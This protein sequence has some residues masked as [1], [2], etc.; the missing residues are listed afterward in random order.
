MAPRCLGLHTAKLCRK[1]SALLCQWI[2][3]NR[4]Q[5]LRTRCLHYHC[6]CPWTRLEQNKKYTLHIFKLDKEGI[7]S[8]V[9]NSVPYSPLYCRFELFRIFKMKTYWHR[10]RLQSRRIVRERRERGRGERLSQSINKGR[11]IKTTANLTKR[12]RTKCRRFCRLSRF[13]SPSILGSICPAS[14]FL[15]C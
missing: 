4:G 9:I 1:R 5:E 13:P 11:D 14:H 7:L 12:V 2:L 8:S 10:G 3:F 6:L 15:L